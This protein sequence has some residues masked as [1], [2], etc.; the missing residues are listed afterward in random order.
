MITRDKI[1]GS[2]IVIQV[3]Q[4]SQAISQC[5]NVDA[6]T[7][8]VPVTQEHCSLTTFRLCFGSGPFDK[9]QTV[10]VVRL[11]I[12]LQSKMYVSKDRGF[13]K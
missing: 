5:N 4:G 1:H 3:F 2:K 8:V 13:F 6:G 11:A 12:G 9:I 7:V 10:V